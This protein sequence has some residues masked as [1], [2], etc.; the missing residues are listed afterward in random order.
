MTPAAPERA[1]HDPLSTHEVRRTVDA[2]DAVRRT[3]ESFVAGRPATG[4][5]A[6]LLRDCCHRLGSI[7]AA[8]GRGAES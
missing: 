8:I 1:R 4:P 2:L 5:D 3:L 6:V 7:I